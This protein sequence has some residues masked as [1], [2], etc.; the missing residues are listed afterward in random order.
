MED[1]D[2]SIKTDFIVVDKVNLPPKKEKEIGLS[3]EDYDLFESDNDV[4]SVDLSDLHT[5]KKNK[6]MTKKGNMFDKG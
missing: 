3:S 4:I 1:W 5:K 6:D 2:K